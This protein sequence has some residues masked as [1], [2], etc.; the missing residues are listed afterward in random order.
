MLDGHTQIVT[1]D[2]NFQVW[3]AEHVID[4]TGAPQ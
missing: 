1:S 4:S 3:E 2:D